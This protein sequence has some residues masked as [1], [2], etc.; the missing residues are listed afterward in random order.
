MATQGPVPWVEAEPKRFARELAAMPLVAPDLTFE[1]GRW[2]GLL[3]VWPF[4]RDAPDGLEAFLAGQRC[5]VAIEY[6]ESF[7]MIAPRFWPLNP[8]PPLF[9]RSMAKWHV[10]PDGSGVPGKRELAVTAAPRRTFGPWR[11]R[12]ATGRMS[13]ARTTTTASMR[14]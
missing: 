6:L 3:P 11:R 1:A 10:S 13:H 12:D 5:R 4:D 9:Q 8:E 2:T 14:P 7:P